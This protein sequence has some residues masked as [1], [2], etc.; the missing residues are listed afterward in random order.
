[1][2]KRVIKK[3]IIAL[4]ALP[5]LLGGCAKT[6]PASNYVEEA[7]QQAVKS[8]Y[9]GTAVEWLASL[10]VENVD[11]GISAYDIAVKNGYQGTETEW[12]DSL[13]GPA[14]KSAYELAVDGGY[15]GTQEEWLAS[16]AGE[17]N[18]VSIENKSAYQLA[19]NNGY[20]GTEEDWIRSL[21][22]NVKGESG[23][24]GDKGD[25]GAQGEKGDKGDIG[26][27]GDTGAAGKNGKNAYEIACDN[28]YTGTLTEWLASLIGEQGEAGENGGS[29]YDI[30]V[31]NGY[32]GTQQEW[33]ASLVGAKGAKGEK[34][35]AGEIGKSAYELAQENGYI[36]TE[37]E[38]L[39]T[40]VGEKGAKGDTGENGKSAYELACENGFEGTLSEWLDSLI[41]GGT[42]VK[43]PKGD[44]GD[45]GAD[46]KSAYE[47]AKENNPN[48]GTLAEWLDSL[49]GKNGIDGKSGTDGKSAY[50]LACENGFDGTIGDWLASLVGSDGA[51]GKS[52]Y[53]L[54]KEGGFNGSVQDWLASL[55]GAD[56]KSAY[57]LAV[58]NGYLGSEKE[59]LASLKGE[60]GDTGLTGAQGEKGDKG[61]TGLTGEKGEKGD[62]GIGISSAYINDERHLI[63]VLSN[64]VE[65]DAGYVGGEQNV[66]SYSVTFVDYDN[67]LLKT[68]VVAA[69]GSATP[70]AD[71]VRE[72]YDFVGWDGAYT[73]I[74]ADTVIVAK[75]VA[76]EPEVKKYTVVFKDYDGTVLKTEVVSAGEAATAPINPSR[77]GYIFTGWDKNFE[78]ITAD[79]E[80]IA[81]YT[82]EVVTAPTIKVGSASGQPGETVTIP[83]LIVN[84]P[85]ILGAKFVATFDDKLTLTKAVKGDAFSVIDYTAPASLKSGCFFNWDGLENHATEDGT[86]LTLTFTISG[87]AVSGEKLNISFGYNA[88]DVYAIENDDFVDITL[89]MKSG[90]IT[91]E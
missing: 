45:T 39:K 49:A 57:E 25:T 32:V 13:I 24:K 58:I 86:I 74:N 35:E 16:L 2:Q 5:I 59:W 55:A 62:D 63:L 53:D 3:G 75:Y 40:L 79:I 6:E 4:C 12:L 88:G 15:I 73:N 81:Q 78:V 26:A 8:G 34:G 85:G 68:E 84:N 60:K 28:G 22:N 27:Q 43:G 69:G 48:I 17:N 37:E 72:G 91:V 1:M 10:A 9:S 19:V 30:A 42:G 89:T 36:G 7:Y 33:L 31:A 83:V 67:R 46:G 76:K 64:G 87:D 77:D 56:G 66:D 80:I 18:S 23:E 70:P 14:G 65:I 21:V 29:A 38:W 47:L 52:A 82:E 90:V 71:P 41:G 50:Q 54:A 51:D 61:D 44:K 20:T 11:D